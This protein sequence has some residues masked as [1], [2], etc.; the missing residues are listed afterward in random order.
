MP[1]YEPDYVEHAITNGM[2]QIITDDGRQ[3]PAYWAHP[4]IGRL[5]PGATIIHD[6][7]G[8]SDMV[9]RIAN[10][11]AQTGY[12][13]IVPDLFN[14]KTTTAPNEAMSLVEQLGSAGYPAIHG[15]L[16]VLETHS[17][18]NGN[19]AAV[20]IGM[21]GSLAYEAAIV[22]E[23]LE[24]AIVYGGFLHRYLGRF[25]D[26]ITPICA[27]YGSDE[28]HIP[29]GEIDKFRKELRNSKLKLPHEVRMIDGL[30]HDLFS[31]TLTDAQ[32]EKSRE[33]LKHTFEFLDI[34]LQSNLK[35][36]E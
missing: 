6:W 23:D 3:I 35:P 27:F 7:W 22:R 11:F 24:A 12:Y 30:G 26:C 19:V 9:R 10:L 31:T 2:I 34:H 16:S 21:G 1:I 18:C 33:V 25:K 28:P 17:Q 4:K 13:V 8:L 5:F 32:R 36:A 15:A 20:G 14:G 29:K